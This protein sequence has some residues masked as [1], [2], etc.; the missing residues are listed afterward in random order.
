M[1]QPNAVAIRA[2]EAL[3]NHRDELIRWFDP[4][5]Y[6]EA[7]R[8]L[9]ILNRAFEEVRKGETPLTMEEPNQPNHGLDDGPPN[10]II[11]HL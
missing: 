1:P 11:K 8:V 3:E 5:W 4:R 2:M 10:S 9:S 7:R 6:P